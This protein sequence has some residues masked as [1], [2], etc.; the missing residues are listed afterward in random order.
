M[1]LVT[2]MYKCLYGHVFVTFGYISRSGITGSYGNSV[3]PLTFKLSFLFLFLFF[4][5]FSHQQ[6]IKVLVS[7]DPQQHLLVF[8]F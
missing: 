8:C 3:Q 2:F 5:I 4:Y 7:L 6:C 1:L